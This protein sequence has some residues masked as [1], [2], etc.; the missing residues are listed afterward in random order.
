[1]Y[2][3][4]AISL[5]RLGFRKTGFGVL[6]KSFVSLRFLLFV[7]LTVGIVR[8]E[9]SITSE[10]ILRLCIMTS[11]VFRSACVGLGFEIL[12]TLKTYYDFLFYIIK[13]DNEKVMIILS[14]AYILKNTVQHPGVKNC[15]SY[16]NVSKQV[17]QRTR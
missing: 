7:F 14:K 8:D 16:G 5:A 1:M 11:G 10:I 13:N 6:C 17:H 4:R 9:A 2:E 15:T 12:D 3:A